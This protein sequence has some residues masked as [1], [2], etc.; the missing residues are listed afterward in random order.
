MRVGG[1]LNFQPI[2]QRISETVQDGTKVTINEYQ[3]VECALSIGAQINDADHRMN[4]SSSHVL[5]TPHSCGK[6]QNKTLYKIATP[7]R[8]LTKFGIVDYVPEISPKPNL[9][10]IGSAGASG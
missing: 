10:T 6:G 1:I 2:S 7:E 5:T 3:E 4:G 9:V 8:I